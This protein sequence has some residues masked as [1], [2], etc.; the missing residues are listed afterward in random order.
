MPRGKG[1]RGTPTKQA[2]ATAQRKIAP[3][4]VGKTPPVKKP[5]PNPGKKPAPVKPN[6]AKP[7]KKPVPA[8]VR[9][10][11]TPVKKPVRKPAP[12]IPPVTVESAGVTPHTTEVAPVVDSNGVVVVA[13]V[14]A[15]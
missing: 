11:G 2:R 13:P 5:N 10:P 8:P 15:Q 6:P 9:A 12:A 3:R 7:V 1:T 14:Q 4:K